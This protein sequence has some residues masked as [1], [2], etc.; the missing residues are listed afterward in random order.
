MGLD[1]EYWAR[2]L[3]GIETDTWDR[4]GKIVAEQPVPNLA[5][6]D[7]EKLLRERFLGEFDQN[8]PA[9]SAIKH[10]GV[11]NYRRARRGQ[12]VPIQA[13]R[14]AV[15]EL[16][17]GE[18]SLPEIRLRMVCSSGFYVRSLAHDIGESLGC[19]AMLKDLIRT[20]IGDFRL[21]D[22]WSLEDLEGILTSKEQSRATCPN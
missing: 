9:Y 17:V 8:P 4:D 20:R 22:A 12:T 1:K 21:D 15:Q 7:L 16:E 3:L 5:Q 14:V 10:E 19:G 18:F 2:I 11:P 13:R 6:A